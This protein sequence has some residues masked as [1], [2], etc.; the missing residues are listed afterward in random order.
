[1]MKGKTHHFWSL[2]ITS[3]IFSSMTIAKTHNTLIFGISSLLLLFSI[4]CNYL[5]GYSHD[6]SQNAIDDRTTWMANEKK[7]IR[8]TWSS[9]YTEA[10]YV[11]FTS[12]FISDGGIPRFFSVFLASIGYLLSIMGSL[13]PDIDLNWG[14]QA[15][16]N[17]VTHSYI[18]PYTI[19][20]VSMFAVPYEFK[21]FL[22]LPIMF[23]IGYS[24]HLFL[25]CI[26][27]SVRKFGE[28]LE[29]LF[30][31]Y[32]SPGN[33]RK[34]DSDY[35]HSW[36]FISGTVLLISS[37]FGFLRFYGVPYFTYD[38]FD[39]NLEIMWTGALIVLTIIGSFGF[40]LWIL[41]FAA[42]EEEI[43]EKERERFIQKKKEEIIYE[44][45]KR[46]ILSVFNKK[47]VYPTKE[48]LIEA[49]KEALKDDWEKNVDYEGIVNQMLEN[50][51]IMYQDRPVRGYFKIV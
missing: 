16:R 42:Y 7:F 17:P 40:I 1:M 28:G 32:N 25:D 39:R 19:F 43:D 41:L 33:I 18:F 35:E 5:T 38:V 14:I 36:L 15:H 34:I 44:R 46:R 27:S 9:I 23:E 45:R 48:E 50:N 2:V 26:P 3:I 20:I 21:Y 13:F 8:W 12:N 29:E 4:A 47:R 51:W 30:T 31:F 49:L 37:I 10:I 24:S 11:I 22:I 6:R